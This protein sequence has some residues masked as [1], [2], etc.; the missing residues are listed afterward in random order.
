MKIDFSTSLYLGMDHGSAELRKWDV[1]TS[2]VPAAFHEIPDAIAVGK[3]LANLQGLEDGVVAPSTLHLFWDWFG[4][5]NSK[6]DLIFIDGQIYRIGVWGAERAMSK[7]VRC[8]RFRHQ[9]PASLQRLIRENLGLG[10]RP[11]IVT[12][13]WCPVC[14]KPA[15]LHNYL[16]LIEPYNGLLVID[17]TQ[18][19]GIL[20]RAPDGAMPYG[21]GGGGL[22]PYLN[23]ISDQV[24]AISSLAKAFGVPMAVLCGSRF[25]VNKFRDRSETRV[26]SSP[27]SATA[28]L[29]AKHALRQN[30]ACGGALRQKL[31]KNIALFKSGMAQG[32]I[33][34]KGGFFPIQ[35]LIGLHENQVKHLHAVLWAK[36]IRTVPVLGHDKVPKLC[37]LLGARHSEEQ[38]LWACRTFLSTLKYSR[39]LTFQPLNDSGNAY[40]RSIQP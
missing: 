7:G 38:I 11:V 13:G 6:K 18:A 3:A 8:V 17:D 24:I 34:T 10:Q 25:Q 29:A 23:I 15:P 28:L 40:R 39:R 27:P 32:G 5:L 4:G 33:A 9:T 36:G 22:L 19:L 2:G 20:G 14:G 12:D 35:T 21:F 37:W 1:L 26:H 30:S 16:E 31:L